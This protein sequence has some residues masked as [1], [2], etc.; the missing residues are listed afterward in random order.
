MV[1]KVTL[2]LACELLDLPEDN[3]ATS[4]LSTADIE[5]LLDFLLHVCIVLFFFA[6]GLLYS[7]TPRHRYPLTH[8]RPGCKSES[9]EAHV[10]T[11][12]HD[13]YHTEISVYY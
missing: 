3:I 10:R 4:E 9:Q 12:I 8:R 11:D 6:A 7:A 1:N 5:L 2:G 13:E